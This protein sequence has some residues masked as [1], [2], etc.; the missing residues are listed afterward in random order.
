[1]SQLLRFRGEIL[2]RRDGGRGLCAVEGLESRCL[3]SDGGE[4][5]AAR[6]VSW[7]DDYIADGYSAA[8]YRGQPYPPVIHDVD[9][10]GDG[11]TDDD[12]V[13]Y[14]SFSTSEPLNPLGPGYRTYKPS[15]VF[16]GGIVSR[17]A[18]YRRP[19]FD[20]ATVQ[21]PEGADLDLY[22]PRW[23][24]G[25]PRLYIV[26]DSPLAYSDMT[27]FIYDGG[28]PYPVVETE[29]P[30][31][32]VNFHA[33]FLWQKSGFLNGGDVA[34]RVFFDADSLLSVDLARQWSNVNA[35]WV[36]QDGDEYYVSEVEL[37]RVDDQGRLV[38]FGKTNTAAPLQVRWA[39][40]DPLAITDPADPN[41][42][43]FDQDQ[44]TWEYRQFNDV[45]AVGLY[46]EQ[47]VLGYYP[48]QVALVFDYLTVDAMVVPGTAG[49]LGLEVAEYTVDEAA[50]IARV[51]V[52]RVDGLWGEVSVDYATIDGTAVAG[53]D[54]TFVSG[55]LV[56]AQGQSQATFD[57]PISNDS[58]LEGD[59]Y[60]RVVLSNAAGGAALGPAESRILIREDAVDKRIL[61]V[62]DAGGGQLVVYGAGATQARFSATPFGKLFRGGVRVAAAD[63]NGD[64]VGDAVAAPGP[65]TAPVVC[66]YNGRNGKLIRRITAYGSTF[67]GGVYV[68]AGDVNGDGVPDIVTGPGPGAAPE[69]R[70]FSG[71][72]GR[73]VRKF[74]AYS[75][76]QRTGVLVAAVQFDS[77]GV[78]DIL[79]VP[80][81]GAASNLRIFSGKTGKILAVFPAF[82]YEPN[83]TGGVNVAGVN[84]G[85][86]LDV[87]A[88]APLSTI[89]SIVRIF[90]RDGRTLIRSI[91]VDVN[92]TTGITVAAGDVTGDDREDIIVGAGRGS[93]PVVRYYDGRTGV[94]VSRLRVLSS[95][96]RDGVFVA[97]SR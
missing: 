78:A 30:D 26:T 33:V 94:E 41:Y 34:G 42:L 69:V 29:G 50:G 87:L 27:L 17:R 91:E 60:F 54:Y 43:D 21:G 95:K 83:F 38:P 4:P 57:V 1:M 76:K 75:S 7:W 53:A 20:Q 71:A 25:Y 72:D 13:I 10:D 16:Y 58:V 67:L 3:L 8:W 45:R 47:D 18:N 82:Y 84:T 66:V 2:T 63:F 56:F 59:E 55:T 5:Y 65:G 15:A 19:M 23:P 73:L 81:P 32:L 61:A 48:D 68:A 49:T 22:D 52:R 9:V 86:T 51:T 89:R 12:E 85:G 46:F 96:R 88:I 64:G 14:Y 31:D 44:A 80:G 70:V 24:H 11:N 28:P 40:Y 77:D 37:D 74:L 62:G 93:S 36:V 90:G 97:V 92:S 79:T 35:R 39:R 6:I